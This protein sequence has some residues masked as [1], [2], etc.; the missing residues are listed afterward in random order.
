MEI[1]SELNPIQQEAVSYDTSKPL[2]I[3]AGAG[4][5][6]TR[7]LTHRVAYLIKSQGV[8]PRNILLLTFTNKASE[9]M[10]R[11]VRKLIGKSD[12]TVTGGTFHSFCARY[13][14]RYGEQYWNFRKICNL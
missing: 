10:L 12:E 6:K 13:L 7:I 11:R 3:L 4:S 5:G 1:L 14:R 2:L 9:E 8:N